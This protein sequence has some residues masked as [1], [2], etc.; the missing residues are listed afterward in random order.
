MAGS[1]ILRGS[2]LVSGAIALAL[3]TPARPLLLWNASA[4]STPGLYLLSSPG[5]PAVGDTVVGWAPPWARR[6]AAARNYLPNMVPLV[7]PVAA[8]TGDRV[9]ARNGRIFVNGRS[10]ATQRP[11]DGAG[12]PMPAWSGCRLLKP[13]ELFL[14]SVGV[15]D[16]FDGRYFGVSRTGDMIG[17]AKLLWAR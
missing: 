4:S 10:V 15:R 17:K 8:V 9:C 12:R 16:A 2:L 7:K 3:F 13:G 1:G 5:E 14:V 11:R 6:L